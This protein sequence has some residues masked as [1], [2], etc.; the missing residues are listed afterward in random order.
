MLQNISDSLVAVVIPEGAHHLDLMFSHE[1]DPPSVLVARETQR[2]HMR[3]WITQAA[4]QRSRARSD[5]D[6]VM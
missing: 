5:A 2:E 3:R 6:A 1:D 4:E